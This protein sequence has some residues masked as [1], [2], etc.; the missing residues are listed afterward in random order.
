M[1]LAKREYGAAIEEDTWKAD[2]NSTRQRRAGSDES[3]QE[4]MMD[5]RIRFRN[6]ASP[7]VLVCRISV[8][9]LPELVH[10]EIPRRRH[11]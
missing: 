6:T 7:A 1:T 8:H 2:E 3:C 10:R 5:C 9:P 4:V 11:A